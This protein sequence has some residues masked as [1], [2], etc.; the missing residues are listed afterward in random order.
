[1]S[2]FSHFH[3]FPGFRTSDCRRCCISCVLNLGSSNACSSRPYL[4]DRHAKH[5]G[6]RENQEE[7]PQ[8]GLVGLKVDKGYKDRPE[9]CDNH[10]PPHVELCMPSRVLPKE[11]KMRLKTMMRELLLFST[12]ERCS[13]GS[14]MDA[15]C[16]PV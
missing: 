1:M 16:I 6:T 13:N 11:E 7:S 15:S 2:M 9:R 10:G 4:V 8:I 5:Y 3:E 12:N 14:G